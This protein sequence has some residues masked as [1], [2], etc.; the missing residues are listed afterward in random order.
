MIF[1][2]YLVVLLASAL[3]LSACKNCQTCKATG[4]SDVS[5]CQD[6]FASKTLYEGAISTYELAG[7]N[8]K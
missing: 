7:W 6:D 4:F 8:C 1:K 2:K 3:Y 5:I